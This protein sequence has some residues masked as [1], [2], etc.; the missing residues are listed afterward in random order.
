MLATTARTTLQ[1]P[2]LSLTE[3]SLTQKRCGCC[4]KKL[5]LT[6]DSCGKCRIRYCGTHR[7][8]EAHS[9]G[10]DYRAEKVRLPRVVADKMGDA[11]I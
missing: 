1:I 11:R 4:R 10:H 5:T 6:D 2:S 7:L 3:E 8:P 9:C